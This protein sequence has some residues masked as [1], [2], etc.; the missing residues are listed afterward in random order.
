MWAFGGVVN[1]VESAQFAYLST[2]TGGWTRVAP[3]IAPPARQ[4]CSIVYLSTCTPNSGD[5]LVLVGGLAGGVRLSDVWSY[6]L[7]NNSWSQPANAAAG[8]PPAGHSAAAV[9]SPDAS[10][11]FLFGGDTQNGVS[12]DVYVLAPRGNFLDFNA[13]YMQNV[14]LGQPASSSTV[15]H[16]T[17]TP[18]TW[19]VPGLAVDGNTVTNLVVGGVTSCFSSTTTTQAAGTTGVGEYD[20]WWSVDLGSPQPFSAIMI[21]TRAKQEAGPGRNAGFQVWYGNSN[22]PP[23]SGPNNAIPPGGLDGNNQ[24]LNTMCPNP[25]TDIVDSQ[26]LL[27]CSGVGRYVFIYLPPASTLTR[28]LELCEVQVLQRRPWTWRLLSGVANVG[29][30]V[31]AYA[32]SIYFNGLWAGSPEQANDGVISTAFPYMSHTLEWQGG[33]TNG[34]LTCNNIFLTLDLGRDY[35]VSQLNVWTRLDCCG[36]RRTRIEF[37]IGDTMDWTY[38][39]LVLPARDITPVPPAT[40]V[41][42]PVSARGRYVT[43][44]RRPFDP[45]NCDNAPGTP[46]GSI[47]DDKNV[48]SITELQV[49]GNLL[50]NQP[51]PRSGAAFAS[52]RGQLVVAS[53]SDGSGV[54]LNDVRFFDMTALIWAP[55]MAPLGT[56]PQ[57]RSYPLLLPLP[58]G[59]RYVIPGNAGTGSLP[60]NTLMLSGGLDNSGS[61]IGDVNLL[62]F[63]ACGPSPYSIAPIGTPSGIASETCTQAGTL[64]TY[65]CAPGFTSNNLAGPNN[66]IVCSRGGTWLGNIPV[67]V[68]TVAPAVPLVAASALMGGQYPLR[69]EFQPAASDSAPWPADR[70]LVSSVPTDWQ[71]SELCVCGA[72]SALR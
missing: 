47:T 68:P 53:G 7:R 37:Y 21:Y 36:G 23:G 35:D 43:I 3:A 67:C 24:P 46:S 1:G 69:V 15:Y 12:S 41:S 2:S 11:M 33:T 40:G 26:L 70:F 9:A 63:G 5:C 72:G 54:R 32:S 57:A 29:L 66:S 31:K 45:T 18:S 4:L 8:R 42:Y 50:L 19:A 22:T 27:P 61:A 16:I 39:T 30:N 13:A 60:A 56:A 55:A 52:Y 64:C 49:M 51:A 14:A 6:S 38:S 10:Q 48:L 71:V 20:P 58:N 65:T 62:S 59:T 28:Y 44:R 17:A 34:G 25:N